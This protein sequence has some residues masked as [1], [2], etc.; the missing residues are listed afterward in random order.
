ML[1]AAALIIS[2]LLA[3]PPDSVVAVVHNMGAQQLHYIQIGAALQ[4]NKPTLL[5]IHGSPGDASAW[6]AVMKDSLLRTHCNLVSVD[7]VGYGKTAPGQPER[8]LAKQAARIAQLLPELPRPIVVVGHS[9]G[10]PV[11]LQLAIDNGP[12]IDGLLIVAGSVDPNL[13]K[14]EWYQRVARWGIVRWMV[15]ADLYVCNEE[16]MALQAELPKQQPHLGGIRMPVTVVQG[17]KD[18]LVPPANAT[19][20][21]RHLKAASL[22]VLRYPSLNHFIPFTE[23]YLVRDAALATL[24]RLGANP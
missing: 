20:L 7:R 17:M 3:P 21:E 18:N 15:P 11:A 2:H 6:K 16:I 1:Q 22:Q 14:I 12:Q 23:P 4:P 5:F 8:S 19:Y 10:G 9:Y 24:A 13:E